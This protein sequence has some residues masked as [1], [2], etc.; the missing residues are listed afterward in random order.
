MGFRLGTIRTFTLAIS[1]YAE[2]ARAGFEK[3]IEQNREQPRAVI[4]RDRQSAA[5]VERQT[6]GA[7][8]Q[9]HRPSGAAAKTR[10]ET[11]QRLIV[12][13]HKLLDSGK[14]GSLHSP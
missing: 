6:E 13:V 4:G 1:L 12:Q 2:A 9:C 8:R 10:G 7:L 14:V 11:E 3:F 5:V